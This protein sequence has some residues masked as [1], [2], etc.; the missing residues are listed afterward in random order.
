ML[1]N[2]T[3]YALIEKLSRQI[4]E[5]LKN[6]RYEFDGSFDS[7]QEFVPSELIVLL[8]SIVNGCRDTLELGFS[9]PVKTIADLIVYNHKESSRTNTQSKHRRHNSYKESPTLI[10]IG[11][12]VF[13]AT[14]SRKIID[15][16]HKL[17]LCI[18]Y[19]RILRLTQGLGEASIDL[20]EEDN[21]VIPGILRKGIFTIGAK[22]N[23]DKDGS[24]TV[25]KSHYHGTSLSIF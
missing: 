13:A 21:A 25:T 3:L 17:G 8:D 23:I 2:D 6:V 4:R 19:D 20:F 16:L 15:T 10:Y 7:S 14:R 12:K 9:I 11:L 22:D 18:S 24:S 5:K 1:E